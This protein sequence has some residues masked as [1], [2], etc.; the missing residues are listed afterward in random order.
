MTKIMLQL[1]YE[2]IYVQSLQT[3]LKVYALYFPLKTL[4]VFTSENNYLKQVL[5][6][7]K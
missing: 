3:D 1:P 7:P 5:C 2:P 6:R 4:L